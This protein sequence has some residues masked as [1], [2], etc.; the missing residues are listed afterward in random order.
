[1]TAIYR[2]IRYAWRQ[3]APEAAHE[4]VFGGKSIFSKRLL[5][6]KRRLESG[7]SHNEIY[8]A[9]YYARYTDEMTVSAVGIV[10]TINKMLTPKSVID[11][12]CGSGE[13][14]KRF[15]DV[16]IPAKGVDLSEAALGLCRAKG[17]DV[18]RFDLEAVNDRL[19]S[20]NA[21]LVMSLEVAE[22]LPEPCADRYVDLLC[23]MARRFVIITAAPPGQGG[24]D[25]VNEQPYSYWVGKFD[26]RGAQFS[27]ALTEQL[28]HDWK[29]SG[30]EPS[31]SR[32]VMVF[33]I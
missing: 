7:A 19:I 4:F 14:L 10:D 1:M 16:G 27:D 8:D 20:W 5:S 21:D 11:V 18:D 32:N 28:R 17:L 29:I 25:H 6:V 24:T 22:H 2:S 30:V 3:F 12:G 33:S 9:A 31:R 13:V 23:Y 15:N 26:R